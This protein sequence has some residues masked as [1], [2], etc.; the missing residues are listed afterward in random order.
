MESI[1]T[2]LYEY[3][4]TYVVDNSGYMKTITKKNNGQEYRESIYN[5]LFGGIPEY[6]IQNNLNL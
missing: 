5:G 2:S 6:V 3:L 4:Y 1:P